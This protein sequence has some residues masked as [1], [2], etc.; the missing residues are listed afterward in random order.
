MND[1]N[2]RLGAIFAIAFS[3]VCWIGVLHFFVSC[4]ASKPV[5]AVEPGLGLTERLEAA[6]TR[7]DLL[8]TATLLSSEPTAG[9]AAARLVAD[10]PVV[11]ERVRVVRDSCGSGVR[12]FIFVRGSPSPGN[13]LRVTFDPYGAPRPEGDSYDWPFAFVLVEGSAAPLARPLELPGGCQLWIHP[14]SKTALVWSIGGHAGYSDPLLSVS[15]DG[16]LAVLDVLVQEVPGLMGRTFL[17]QLVAVDP[18]EGW[19]SSQLYE[20]T[21]GKSVR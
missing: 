18:P 17:A 1:R 3:L 4:A 8:G 21:I 15:P 16:R 9:A 6:S 14:E 19:K 20:I 7:R 12:P 11:L 13:H 5:A 2:L 10:D